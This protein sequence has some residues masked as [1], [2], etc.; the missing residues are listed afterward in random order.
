[1]LSLLAKARGRS[2][3]GPPVDEVR[4]ARKT[5]ILVGF[6]ILIVWAITIPLLFF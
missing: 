4:A 2:V 1:M 3:S 6:A 5:L